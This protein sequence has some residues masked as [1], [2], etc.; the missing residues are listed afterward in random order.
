MTSICPCACHSTCVADVGHSASGRTTIIAA[1]HQVKNYG[2]QH[3]LRRNWPKCQPPFHLPQLQ[4]LQ[5]T[6]MP[7]EGP[8]QYRHYLKERRQ[9][10]RQGQPLLVV[11]GEARE[12]SRDN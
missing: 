6:L 3:L 11:D 10:R 9:G 8:D 4:R 5:P 12:L 7:R 2:Y 1:Y